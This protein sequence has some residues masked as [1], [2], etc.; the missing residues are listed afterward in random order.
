MTALERASLTIAIP[1]H[2]LDHAFLGRAVLPAVEILEI[3]ASAVR[4]RFPGVDLRMMEE[5]LFPRFL[6]L[7]PGIPAVAAWIERQSLAGGRVKAV[8]GTA[9]RSRSGAIGRQVVHGAVVFGGT[10]E[11]GVPGAERKAAAKGGV[12]VP[13]DR[14]YRELV[15][16]GPAYRNARDPI[17]LDEEGAEALV[18]APAGGDSRRHLGSPF[19]LDAALHVVSAWCQRYGGAVTFPVGFG[20]RRVLLPVAPGETCRIRAHARG[21][22]AGSFLFDLTI[23]GPR[24]RLR[25]ALSGI[26]MRDVS[27]GRLHPPAW[28]LSGEAEFPGK[29]ETAGGETPA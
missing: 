28:I 15:P 13:A 17:L 29:A 23:R 1:P 9:V 24:G 12:P 27:R 6:V 26:R 21:R 14:L 22:E 19:P 3:L 8:L 20:R 4:E 10:G 11:E 18:A 2:F 5:A 16:F 7:E 25:E